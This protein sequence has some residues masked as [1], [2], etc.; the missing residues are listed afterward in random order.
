MKSVDQNSLEDQLQQAIRERDQAQKEL[1]DSKKEAREILKKMD[2]DLDDIIDD[3]QEEYNRLVND[4]EAGMNRKIDPTIFDQ[5]EVGEFIITSGFN[6]NT[7]KDLIN[8][9]KYKNR[10]CYLD[11]QGSEARYYFDTTSQ[12]GILKLMN[13]TKEEAET[14]KKYCRTSPPRIK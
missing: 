3:A 6:W 9:K 8:E 1:I 5:Q 14:Y 7:I 12:F 11:K 4:L 13:I 10:W 2:D